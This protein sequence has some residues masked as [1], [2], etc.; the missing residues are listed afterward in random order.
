MDDGYGNKNNKEWKNDHLVNLRSGTRPAFTVNPPGRGG[1][2]RGPA[3]TL[4]L[5]R[6]RLGDRENIGPDPEGGD[7]RG[8]TTTRT[9][10]GGTSPNTSRRL[11]DGAA[12]SQHGSRRRRDV[13][14]LLRCRLTVHD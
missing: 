10:D 4:D 3:Q 14:L 11:A 1:S 7:P 6:F 8:T 5:G 9:R 2:A 13:V 12:L